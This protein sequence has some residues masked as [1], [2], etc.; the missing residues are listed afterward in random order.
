[1][2]IKGIDVPDQGATEVA[3]AEA[4]GYGI[5]APSHRLPDATRLGPVRLQIADLARSVTYYQDVLGLRILG[6]GAGR[7][8][9]GAQHDDRPLVELFE[10]PG[11]TAVPN[12][13]RLGLFHFAILLP[14]RGSLGRFAAHLA[15]LGIRAG[16]ADH[17]VSE[18]MY[19][20]D[21]DGLGIEV[22]ADRPRSAWG[23]RGRELVIDTL[24]LDAAALVKEGRAEPWTGMPAGTVIGHVHLHVGE[25]DRAAAFY[26]AGLGLDA[27][28]WTYPGALFLSAGGY[29]HHLGVNTWARPEA[30]GPGPEE[31]QLLEWEIV[32]PQAEDANA[33]SGSLGAGGHVAHRTER[34]WLGSDPWGTKVRVVWGGVG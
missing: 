20:Y 16:S 8:I 23:R 31:A 29:H 22:Y 18:A 4:G 10:R 15:T 33:A 13:G 19:L 21:P 5:R 1:L 24:P 27:T 2:K 6:R 11:A 26:H 9:L 7:A 25:L 17:I 14:D 12:R 28:M 34:G 32:V 30:P 3:P